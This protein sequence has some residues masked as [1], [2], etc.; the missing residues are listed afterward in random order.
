MNIVVLGAGAIG[1]L[2][3]ALLS[4]KNDVLLI[5]RKQHIRAINKNGLKLIGKTNIT[6]KISATDSIEKV[7]SS[8]DLLILT[9]KAC[10]TE[11]AI[12]EAKS[13]I[14]SSTLVL[15]LQNG[16]GNI[17]IIK[18]AVNSKQVIAGITTHG[19]VFSKP[20]VI[21]HTGKGTTIVGEL[22]GE[23]SER[24]ITI[25]TLFNEAGIE[26]TVSNDIIKEIWT[27]AVV[28]SSINPLTTLFQCKNGYLLKNPLL[29]NIVKKVCNES[30]TVAN[31]EGFHLQDDDMLQKTEK[32]IRDTFENYSSMLQSIQKGKKTE[33]ESIT[34]KLVDFGKQHNIKTTMNELLLYA[35]TSIC[36]KRED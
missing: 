28:N 24:A 26:A 1:S 20:S 27:K 3:G 25:A 5:G 15:S 8:P 23:K 21:S 4:K 16:L 19:A 29:K 35:I 33:I 17:D 10:D 18:K 2:F 11:T 31:S 9:V 12:K 36:E 6:V 14:N 22:H 34:G 32:V 30:T 7:K 13:V